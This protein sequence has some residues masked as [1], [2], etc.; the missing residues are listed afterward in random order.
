MDPVSQI[1]ELLSSID[2][3]NAPSL[4][5]KLL[6]LKD[7]VR[8]LAELKLALDQTAIVAI[9]D[10]KGDITAVNDKFCEI[11][12]YSR[13][14]LVGSTH[15]IVNSGYHDRQFFRQMWETIS[16][17]EVWHGEIKNRAKDGKDYW[18]KTYIVPFLDENGKPERYVSIQTDITHLK[19]AEE[20]MEYLFYYDEL[21]GLANRR[22][23]VK[24]LSRY[25]SRANQAKENLYVVF[26]DLD[27]FSVINDSIGHVVGDAILK[28]VSRRLLLWQ[29]RHH[30][31]YVSRY[32][33]DEFILLIAGREQHHMEFLLKE[34]KDLLSE[35]IT[36]EGNKIQ[37]SVSMGIV[38]YPEDGQTATSLIQNAEMA[39]YYAKS[40][41]SNVAV[42]YADH[43][44]TLSRQA[45]IENELY[46][47]VDQRGFDLVYQ[48]KIDLQSGRIMGTE[49]LVRW[50][51]PELGS[52]SPSEFIPIA[53]RNKL[54]I[55]IGTYVLDEAV[56]QTVKWQQKGYPSLAVSVNVSPVQLAHPGFV[57]DVRSILKK[58]KLPPHCLELEITET[59]AMGNHKESLEK[60]RTL[61]KMGVK[62]ALDD[63]GSGYSSLKY[64]SLFGMDTLKIDQSFIQ[65]YS[66]DKDK[67]AL[68]SAIISIGH[69]LNMKVVAEGVETQAQVHYL[70]EQGCDMIQGYYVSPPVPPDKLEPLLAKVFIREE[71][72][73]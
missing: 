68:I 26:F 31:T 13:E 73:A 67:S 61:Q 48:P 8:E 62:I 11:S 43:K 34:V 2:R 58:W 50:R 14:E 9:T 46:K 39:L 44:T 53:E 72:E 57:Q 6:T 20:Q 12:K 45:Q 36:V 19:L 54:I 10:A 56:R 52:V 16:K 23:F 42:Y 3:D 18:V 33:G 25:I 17:G 4:R 29:S 41:G 64:L 7:Q 15:R 21:T 35:S 28:E 37:L 40:Q 65:S 38:A 55:P 47:A 60:L 66:G 27:R 63:F 5:E 1:D 30:S 71:I 69:A 51:H 70:V 24:V 49:A 22:Q 32:G 59:I